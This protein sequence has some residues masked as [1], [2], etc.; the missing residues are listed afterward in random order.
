MSEVTSIIANQPRLA[1]VVLS[2]SA[3]SGAVHLDRSIA[4]TRNHRANGFGSSESWSSRTTIHSSRCLQAGG[5][6]H[7]LGVRQP[8]AIDF[9]HSGS[10]AQ[11]AE[12]SGASIHDRPDRLHHRHSSDGRRTASESPAWPTKLSAMFWVCAIDLLTLPFFCCRS[13]RSHLRRED[14]VAP[15][16][17]RRLLDP[18]LARTPTPRC[19]SASSTRLTSATLFAMAHIVKITHI[20]TPGRK[21]LRGRLSPLCIADTPLHS[22]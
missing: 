17:R 8:R 11:P 22:A 18:G 10:S 14:P 20:A 7:A 1:F 15:E 12:A 5:P 6:Q 16:G 21:P 3:E 9:A 13:R 2:Q 19:S 4:K